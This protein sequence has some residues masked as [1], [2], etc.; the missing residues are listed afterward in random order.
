MIYNCVGAIAA[1]PKRILLSHSLLPITL[2]VYSPSC[3]HSGSTILLRGNLRFYTRILSKLTP[4][5]PLHTTMKGLITSTYNK[6]IERLH[7][8]ERMRDLRQQKERE[9]ETI[10]SKCEI[11]WK[12]VNLARVESPQKILH[13]PFFLARVFKLWVP[14]IPSYA[15]KI[16]SAGSN[17]NQ[18]SI[19]RT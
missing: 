11:Q 6:R 13:C 16:Q 3:R 18:S 10:C 7:N 15:S 4:M 17:T 8:R 12:P 14:R 19:K 5:H 1:L 9:F 2:K